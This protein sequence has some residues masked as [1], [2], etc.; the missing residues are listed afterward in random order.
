MKLIDLENLQVYDEEIKKYLMQ[1]VSESIEDISMVV[2]EDT[3]LSFPLIGSE[4]T[5]YI[6]TTTN[7]A[8]R[9]SDEG[10]KYYQ[11]G[12]DWNDIEMIDGNF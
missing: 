7:Q 4:K 10:L 2:Q 8:Y 1:Q 11:I 9:W 12:S 6:D 3:Y 5:L